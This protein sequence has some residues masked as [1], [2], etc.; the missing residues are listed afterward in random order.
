MRTN[1]RAGSFQSRQTNTEFNGP[2]KNVNP[3]GALWSRDA[4]VHIGFHLLRSINKGKDDRDDRDGRC[5]YGDGAKSV[6]SG[7]YLEILYPSYTVWEEGMTDYIYPFILTGDSDWAVDICA[8]VP[9]GY[10]IAGV[11]DI[12]GNLIASNECVQAGVAGDT[13]V[14]AFRVVDLQSPPPHLTAKL[15]IRHK[16]RS[17]NAQLD[18]EGHRKGKD[19]V[20]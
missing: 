3:P 9:Q 7:S 12:D 1:A 17:V 8:A 10:Q 4:D 13:K 14:L 2:L 6:Y 11:Y 16:G 19:H 18:I 20:K 15:K 5:D